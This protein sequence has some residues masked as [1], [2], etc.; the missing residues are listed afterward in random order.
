MECTKVDIQVPVFNVFTI[1]YTIQYKTKASEPH[2]QGSIPETKGE[3]EAIQS[4]KLGTELLF[5][6]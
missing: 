4:T 1:W 6:F 3:G 2:A 5:P